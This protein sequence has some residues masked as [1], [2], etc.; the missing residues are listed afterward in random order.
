[1]LSEMYKKILKDEL[2]GIYEELDGLIVDY[3][4]HNDVY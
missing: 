1:M 4:K 3:M 2:T